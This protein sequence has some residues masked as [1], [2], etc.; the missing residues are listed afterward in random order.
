MKE[1][2]R[3][4]DDAGPASALLADYEPHKH[5]DSDSDSD[6]SDIEVYPPTVYPGYEAPRGALGHAPPAHPH[7]TEIHWATLAQKRALWWSSALVT[8]MFILSWYA[9]ATIL[10]MYN[11]WMFSAEYYG[12][13]YP[14]FVTACHMVVQWFC[15]GMIRW[16]VPRFRPVERPSRRDYMTRIV[17][18]AMSTGGDIGLSNLS[19]KTITLSLYTMCKSS[20]LIFVLMFAFLF[21]LEKYSFKLVSVI[22]LISI[23]VFLMVFNVTAVS[24]PGLIMVFSASAIGGLRWALTALIMHKRAMGLSN[25]FAT[26]FWLAPLMGFFLFLFSAIFEDWIGM[27]TGSYFA[28][29]LVALKSIGIIALPGAIAFAMVSS[30]YFVI[31]RAG[32]VPL[33]V[34]G[35]FKEVSTIAFSA[36]IFGDKLTALN[37]IGCAITIAGIALYSFHKYQRSMKTEVPLDDDGNV[38][39]TEDASD[40]ERQPL[41]RGARGSHG[42]LA[43]RPSLAQ[44]A[45]PTPSSRSRRTPEGAA[46]PVDTLPMTELSN[47]SSEEDERANRLRDSFEGWDAPGG[48]DY[49]SEVDEDDVARYRTERMGAVRSRWNE[50]WDRPM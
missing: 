16:T 2:E 40:E 20:A 34:A 38:V 32:V 43:S 31:Q 27:F 47:R 25:P 1:E 12:F 37:L 10:S 7:G 29:P 30:E 45:P 49:E 44:Y 50:W 33:S 8:G 14:L 24:I 3:H 35:I 42:S 11:K 41:N 22:G 19:L 26:I 21:R 18:T 28:N 46:T 15:A 36:W 23:G 13:T 4:S 5:T 9:F 6:H 39:P 17:P 48:S